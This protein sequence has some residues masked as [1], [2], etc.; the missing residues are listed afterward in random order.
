MSRRRELGGAVSWAD[1]FAVFQAP[2]IGSI[3]LFGLLLMAIFAVWLTV[4]IGIYDL[5]LGP[6]A[7]ASPVAF[8]RDVFTT[9]AGWMLI[10]IGCGVG[11]LFA[12]LV[13]AISVVA[14]PLLLDRDVGLGAAIGT[15]LRAVAT[16]P[17]PMAAWGL[18]VAVALV[19]GSIPL[20]LG[21]IVVMPVLG[22]ATWHLYR[23]VVAA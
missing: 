1:A 7:P 2:S 10:A 21:L 5:T 3:V 13:L 8:I 17:G 22:H 15:S 12:A 20:F 11:F 9:D 23:R 18:I 4:A 14:V 6:A 19:V 16:N